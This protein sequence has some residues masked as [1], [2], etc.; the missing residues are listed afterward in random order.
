M[1]DPVISPRELAAL[2]DAAILDCRQD[3]AAYRAGHLPGARHA[4]LERD[5]AAPAHDPAHGGRHPLPDLDAFAATLGRW[6]IT[7]GS[8]VVAYDDQGGANA[9][10]RLW[11]MLRAIGHRDVQVVDGGLAALREAGF[12]LTTEEPAPAPQPPYPHHGLVREVA[13]ID[14]VERAR[15][16]ADRRVIDVRAAFRF[17]GDSDPFDPIAGHIAGARNAPYADNLRPDG[18]FKPAEELRALFNHVLDGVA[19]AQTIVQCGSGVTACHTLLA[20]ERAGLSGARLYVGSWSEWCR[21]PDRARE[22][23]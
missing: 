6:G 1:F 2:T 16:A 12:E 22:P 20:M 11:W 9:A 10:A 14:E 4:Q 18:T 17:R 23:R 5:L 19:P 13:D 15:S 7:P 3:T 8:R 21:H